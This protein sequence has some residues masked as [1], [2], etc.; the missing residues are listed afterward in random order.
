MALPTQVTS[1]ADAHHAVM[2]RV[3]AD[4]YLALALAV[5][6]SGSNGCHGYMMTSAEDALFTIERDAAT[7]AIELKS[8]QGAAEWSRAWYWTPAGAAD[9]REIKPAQPIPDADFRELEKLAQDFVAQWIWFSN[10]SREEIVIEV[11]RYAR[12]GYAVHEANLRS[13]ALHRIKAAAGR[14]CDI[15]DYSTLDPEI[16]WVGA[17]IMLCWP[18]IAA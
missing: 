7:G 16:A 3:T 18:G 14:S 8:T 12:L 15:L 11:E 10:G 5:A 6:R 1:K 4:G 2:I 9:Y 13:A 17:A